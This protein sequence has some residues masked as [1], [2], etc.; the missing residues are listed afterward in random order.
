MVGFKNEP[1]GLIEM[2][3][4]PSCFA[5]MQGMEMTGS[6]WS[7]YPEVVGGKNGT[8]TEFDLFGLISP[9]LAQQLTLILELRFEFGVGVGDSHLVKS[10]T[11]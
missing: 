2:T 9:S 7:K 6:R 5:L 8:Q 1:I 11:Y 4:D 10:F 3:C